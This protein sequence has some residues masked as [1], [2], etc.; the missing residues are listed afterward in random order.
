MVEYYEGILLALEEVK[1]QGIS[2]ALQ[3]YD[4]GTEAGRLDAVLR[5]PA[6]QS[7]QLI[8]GGVSATEIRRLAAFSRE[9]KVPYVIPFDS[10]AEAATDF[11]TVYR[12]NM[13]A[14]ARDA[15]AAAAFCDLF[16]EAS[17]VIHLPEGK[18]NQSD[19]VQLLQKKMAEQEIP[20]QILTKTEPTV[21]D[22]RSLLG[23]ARQT[24]FVPADD[25]AEALSR[26]ILPLRQAMD[27]FPQD[28][29]ALF[30]YPAWQVSGVDFRQD[31]ERF[32]AVFFSVYYAH[33]AAPA[34]KA[35]YSRYLRWFNRD[36]INTF[37]KFGLL[38]YD[39]GLFF[40]RALYRGAGAMPDNPNDADAIGIQTDFRFE[41]LNGGAGHINTNLYFVTFRPNG[42]S[43][44]RRI[45]EP[46][47]P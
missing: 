13:P 14:A 38:G 6:M 7:V 2:V 30:G 5:E 17:V 37:P 40:L 27:G 28:A 32:H 3:V 8:I 35:F 22:L 1:R 24:V 31:L 21:E 47:A 41:H 23:D 20:F 34:Y 42:A 10:R 19:F 43:A 12:V 44:I 26:L 9:R 45:E 25:G 46:V 4:T 18:Q 16:R 15:K 29:V 11:A 39:T 33:S 36:L